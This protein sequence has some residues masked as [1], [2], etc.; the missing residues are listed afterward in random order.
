MLCLCERSE[1]PAA[2]LPQC[3]LDGASTPIPHVCPL[4]SVF[5]VARMERLWPYVQMRPWTLL[6]ASIHPPPPGAQPFEA[7]RD[8]TTV[9]W[10]DAGAGQAQNGRRRAA[11]AAARRSGCRAVSRTCSCARAWARRTATRGVPSSAEMVF[12]G[13]AEAEGAEFEQISPTCWVA[14]ARPGAAR[15]GTSRVAP[16]PSSGPSLATS[17]NAR[18]GVQRKPRSAKRRCYWRDCDKNET[19]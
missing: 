16:S 11:A 12:G 8:I 3:V 14:S 6:N 17:A 10:T 18:A 13:K 1:G 4:E 9:R 19:K 7:A 2:L 15:A 5:D